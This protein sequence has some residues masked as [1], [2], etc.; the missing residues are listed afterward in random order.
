MRPFLS[1]LWFLFSFSFILL[2]TIGFSQS[3]SSIQLLYEK[4]LKQSVSERNYWN[5]SLIVVLKKELYSKASFHKK[6]SDIKKIGFV[7]SPDSSF[8]IINWNYPNED[9]THQYHCIIQV[10]V[11]DSCQLFLLSSNANL[12]KINSS[13]KFKYSTTQW[14]GALYYQILPAALNGYTYYLLFGVDFNNNLS[15]RKLIETL[16]FDENGKPFFGIPVLYQQGIP[17]NR[18]IFEY[19]ENLSFN[20]RYDNDYSLI[21]FDNLAPSDPLKSGNYMF[22]GPDGSYNSF[23]LQGDYW[24]LQSMT[25]VKNRKNSSPHKH[26]VIRLKP[27]AVQ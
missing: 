4:T 17:S 16:Y 13:E 25:D 19:A 3:D 26:K 1:L 9:G 6:F 21:V 27:N 2:A 12:L 11:K 23:F 24:Y 20:L 18:V 8:R 7:Y 22:Y 10:P 5:D 14:Y 15:N